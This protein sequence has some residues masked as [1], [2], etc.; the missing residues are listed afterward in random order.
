MLRYGQKLNCSKCIPNEAIG[1]KERKKKERKTN[2][3]KFWA[4]SLAHPI[5]CRVPNLRLER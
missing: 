2:G 4:H 1:L 3:K 5:T